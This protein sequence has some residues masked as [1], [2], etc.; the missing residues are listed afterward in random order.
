MLHIKELCLKSD[1]SIRVYIHSVVSKNGERS[2]RVYQ[3]RVRV[4]TSIVS[5]LLE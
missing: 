4:I 3:V 5:V 1:C 2:I